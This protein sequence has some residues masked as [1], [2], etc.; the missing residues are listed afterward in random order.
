VLELEDHVDLGAGR[1]GVEPR[2]LDR[3]RRS[4]ADVEQARR[5]AGEHLA[6]HLLHELVDAR[7]VD[8]VRRGVAVL[9]GVHDACAQ[10]VAHPDVTVRQSR[11]PAVGIWLQQLGEQAHDVHPEAVDAA[12]EPA[13]HHGVD[14]PPDLGVLPVQVGLL[15]CEEVEVVL[16]GRGVVRPGRSRE[17]RAPVGRLGAGR[18]RLEALARRPPPVP[19]TLGVVARGPGLLE[20][21]VRRAGV[22]DHEVHDQ[23]HPALVQ[24]GDQLV[25]LLER[26][27]QGVHVLVVADV[28]TV[29]G[30]RRPVDR[31]QPDDVDAQPL[32]VVEVVDDAAQVTDAVAVAVREAAGVDLVHHGR[33]PPVTCGHGRQS[34]GSSSKDRTRDRR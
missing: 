22:V 2:L 4:L 8:H 13:V 19:V 29:V 20:P 5:S 24:P 31:A 6:V 9:R 1:V 21:R 7:P 3:R 26:P 23:L 15:G 34:G 12:V 11:R 30:H 27:E 25:E 18:A 10:G 16:A 28:V 17:G 32:E 14:G 33:L